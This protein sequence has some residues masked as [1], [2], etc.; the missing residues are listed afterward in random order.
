MR[1]LNL[2]A[3]FLL[4]ILV[5]ACT[6]DKTYQLLTNDARG[7]ESGDEVYRQGIRVGEVEEVAFDGD[8]V[9]IEISIEEPLYEGQGFSIR[10]GEDGQQLELDR[11][12][13][14]ANALADGA[15]V[16]DHNFGDDLLIGLD[17]L[18]HGLEGLGEALGSAMENAFGRDGEKLERS[19]ERIANRWENT[20]EN[21]GEAI[22]AWA[23]EHEDELEALEFKL[24]K[25]AKE[26]ESDFEAF[27]EEVEAWA[28]NFEG[29]MEDFVDE[30]ERVSDKYEVGSRAWKREMRKVLKDLE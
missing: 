8:Q 9:K 21:I 7:I 17:G 26:H 10:R 6:S 16:T 14:E 5:A 11:P 13:R 30:M 27:G 20:G 1:Y 15:I 2:C 24:E 12:D 3:F 4:A 19:L 29:D 22:E 25:W 28:E 23:E 18:G